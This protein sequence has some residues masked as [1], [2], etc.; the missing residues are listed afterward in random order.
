MCNNLQEHIQIYES[1]FYILQKYKKSE[2]LNLHLWIK[3]HF[4]IWIL[5][6]IS[7]FQILGSAK[8]WSPVLRDAYPLTGVPLDE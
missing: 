1:N 5:R 8:V 6:P 4:L 3:W 2:L 7:L